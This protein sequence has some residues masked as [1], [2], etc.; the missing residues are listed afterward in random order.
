MPCSSRSEA[1]IHWH[2]RTSPAPVDDALRALPLA[3]LYVTDRCNSRCVSCDYWRHGRRDMSLEAAARLLPGFASLGTQVILVSGGEPLLN[4]QW[5]AIARL[6]RGQGLR[7][8]LLTA[9]LA[10]SKHASEVGELFE[11]VT[12]SLDGT[13]R[14]SYAA[15]R[16]VDA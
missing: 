13:A 5:A 8:W 15:I 11:T 2:G 9:G 14:D 16:G 6:L 10:L 1:P 12:V 7:L 4:P 3:I